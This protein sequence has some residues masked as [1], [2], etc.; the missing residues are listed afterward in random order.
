M[1]QRFAMLIRLRF[2]V[3]R[4]GIK[5]ISSYQLPVDTLLQ[6]VV[7]RSEEGVFNELAADIMKL[8]VKERNKIINAIRAL[9]E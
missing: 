4:I 6:D 1:Y 2:D 8:P 7:E 5:N 3:G 9:T